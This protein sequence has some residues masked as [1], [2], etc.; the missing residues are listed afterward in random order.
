MKMRSLTMRA[1]K[2]L[3]PPDKAAALATAASSRA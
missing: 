3:A 1:Y 2:G